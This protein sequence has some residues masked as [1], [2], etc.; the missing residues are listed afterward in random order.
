MDGTI[1]FMR[2]SPPLLAPLFRSEG[3]ARLLAAL[4]LAGEELTLTDLADRADLAYATAHRET[5]RLLDAGL[6]AQRRVGNTRLLSG[7]PDSPLLEP[8]R[9]ILRVATG[10]VVLLRQELEALEGIR[11]AFLF[12]SFAARAHGVPGPAPNDIDVM[13]IGEPAV[14]AVY[15]ACRSVST[16]VGRVVNPTVM[17]PQEW[18]E[19]SGFVRDV[20]ASPVVDVIGESSQW[21]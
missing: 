7:N 20:K 12:G 16:E 5:A 14:S 9:A 21:L 4:L 11:C 3:Q 1:H 18:A 19:Q 2:S 13:V 17:T 6:L 10:P 8:V 15:Q